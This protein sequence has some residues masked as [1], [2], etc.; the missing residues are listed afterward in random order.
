MAEPKDP[1]KDGN[2]DSVARQLGMFAVV[3]SAFLGTSIAGTIVGWLLW[4]YAGFPQWTMAV[5]GALG[6]VSG[7]RQ[8][9]QA[10]KRFER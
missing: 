8:V 4:K 9:M 2:P 5:T 3:M 10:Q 1:K 7:V 6:I